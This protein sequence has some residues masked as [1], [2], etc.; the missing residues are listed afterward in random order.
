MEKHQNLQPEIIKQPKENPEKIILEENDLEKIKQITSGV[1]VVPESIRDQATEDVFKTIQNNHPLNKIWRDE[2]GEVIGYLAFEDFIPNEAY[3][4]YFAT[5]GNTEENP[6]TAIPQI[7]QRAKEVGY[8]KIHF[9]G[10]NQRLNKVL[11]HFGFIKTHTDKSGEHSA[12]HFE[13]RLD[14]NKRPELNEKTREAFEQKYQLR[15]IK[16]VQ[17]TTHSL[18]QEKQKQLESLEL[19]LVK[20]LSGQENFDLTD[21]RKMLLKLKL[22]RYLQRHDSL[23]TNT[24]ADALIET[25]KFLD[26]DKGGFDRLLEIHEQKTLEKIAEM[27]KQKAEQKGGEGI[28]PY[29]ALFQTNSGKY[30]MARLLNM[31]HLE[32]ESQ[33]MNHCV[34]TSDSYIN[35]MKRGDVE[36]LSFRKTPKINQKTQKLEGDEPII[37]IEY[38]VR[39]KTIEQIKKHGDEYLNQD[40]PFYLDFIESLKKLKETENDQRE[41][42]NFK[43]ISESELGNFKVKDYHLLTEDGEVSFRDFDPDSDALVLKMGKMSINPDISKIDA[44]KI[45][46]I[47]EGLEID[48]DKIA[49]GTEEVNENTLAYIGK[50]SVDIYKQIK[51]YPN[52]RHL[53]EEFPD[54]KIFMMTLET[55][56]AV[57]SPETAEA[58]IKEKGVGLSDYTKDILY[59]TEFSKQKENYEI[60]SFSVSDLGFPNGATLRD[61]Y[62]KAKTLGLDLCPAEVGPQLRLKYTDQPNGEYLRIAMEAISDRDGRPSLFGVFCDRGRQWLDDDYG[63]LDNE[64][65]GARRFVFR[66]RKD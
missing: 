12:D 22:A 65:N 58:K 63:N 31:P 43:N 42:R 23:D 33:Y 55:D 7:I 44:S 39:T 11:E 30:Y 35:K 21:Q 14:E 28:N 61:I 10:W 56:L 47:V 5:E 59:K 53:Y 19:D 38:N 13:I 15:L 25:P 40:D 8:T 29:E 66:S 26:K 1:N 37:T 16:E 27:R 34:G 24:L 36:I 54:K 62:A 20:K 60:V 32:E 18:G 4:K 48:P 9:H 46:K 45:F 6:F 57:N 64:W 49:Y 3:A 41:K 50:W 52:I 2:N 17:D 51:Q